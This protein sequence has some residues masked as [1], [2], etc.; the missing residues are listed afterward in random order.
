[1]SAAAA[2]T[3]KALKAAGKA[4][5]PEDIKEPFDVPNFSSGAKA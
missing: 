5:L 1:M 3:Q 4:P 2:L